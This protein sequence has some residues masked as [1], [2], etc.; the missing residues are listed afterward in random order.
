MIPPDILGDIE[1]FGGI[2]KEV[3]PV[4]EVFRWLG[5]V[6][7]IL[8]TGKGDAVVAN[9]GALTF[10]LNVGLIADGVGGRGIDTGEVKRVAHP[11]AINP[12]DIGVEGDAAISDDGEK[13]RRTGGNGN[14]A[15][16]GDVA[17]DE[18]DDPFPGRWTPVHRDVLDP[19]TV[20]VDLVIVGA[21][22]VDRL[23]QTIPDC[24]VKGGHLDLP[25]V[26]VG[27]ISVIAGVGVV[28][29]H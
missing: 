14:V 15:G 24:L 11:P 25:V 19:G 23:T 12:G 18:V 4:G 1:R 26:V 2:D 9:E 3:G 10:K 29:R 5:V 21:A 22:I 28:P 7:D 6:D 16:D 20:G 8:V 13:G 27:R 17:V